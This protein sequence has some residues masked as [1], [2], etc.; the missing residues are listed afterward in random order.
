MYFDLEPKG[1]REDLYNFDSQFCRFTG[2]MEEPRTQSP[3]IVVKGTRRA[4]KTS[5]INTT[6]N[7]LGLPHL[8]V[9]GRK[10]AGMPVITRRDLLK[11]FE[12]GLSEAI[13]KLL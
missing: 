9:D 1:R 11:E 4:G 8:Y 7:E 2:L 13:K 10:F 12:R 3:L 6:L 5:L